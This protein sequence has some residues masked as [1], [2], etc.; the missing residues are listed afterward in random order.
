MI[1]TYLLFLCIYYYLYFV[2]KIVER[3]NLDWIYLFV[4]V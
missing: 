2:I 1:I 3:V 4:Q